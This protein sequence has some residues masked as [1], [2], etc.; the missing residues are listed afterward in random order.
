MSMENDSESLFSIFR[1]DPEAIPDCGNWAWDM[2]DTMIVNRRWNAT[3]G[4]N[5]Q[6][7]QMIIPNSDLPEDEDWDHFG[8]RY[9]TVR[10]SCRDEEGNT[11]TLKSTDMVPTQTAKVYFDGTLANHPGAVAGVS[12]NWSKGGKQW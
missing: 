9:G 8:D 4:S 12:K 5:I 11:F 10:V 3:G 7:S 6:G 1:F 2:P